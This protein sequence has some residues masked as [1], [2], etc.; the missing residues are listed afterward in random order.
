MEIKIYLEINEVQKAVLFFLQTVN[1]LLVGIRVNWRAK[2]FSWQNNIFD[3][4]PCQR[5]ALSDPP[6]IFNLIICA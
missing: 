3:F 6:K 4:G 5:D 2:R 1:C